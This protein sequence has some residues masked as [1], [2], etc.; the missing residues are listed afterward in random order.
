LESHV[1]NKHSLT[2]C[3]LIFQNKSE[4][5]RVKLQAKI[6][7][8]TTKDHNPAIMS[9]FLMKSNTN[10][11]ALEEAQ[12]LMYRFMNKAGVAIRQG[13]L[14]EFHD[15]LSYCVTNATFLKP[16]VK[17]VK[18]GQRKFAS[19]QLKSFSKTIYVLRSVIEATKK[20]YKDILGCEGTHFLNVGHDIWESKDNEYLGISIH[21]I[22]PYI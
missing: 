2:D 13:A 7:A 4:K 14:P 1:K 22:V 19:T 21:M 17:N 3:P 10:E 9:N 5:L 12:M 16:Q 11:N 8:T 18:I 20:W 15:M 6:E